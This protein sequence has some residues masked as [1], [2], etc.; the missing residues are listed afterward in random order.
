[1]GSGE[2]DR[3]KPIH[4]VTV[5]D[6]YIGRYSVTNEEYGR[7]IKATGYQEPLYWGDGNFN[8]PRQPVVSVRWYDAQAVARWA[9]LQF[10]SE[11]Q[12]E[13]ACRAAL[14]PRR[15]DSQPRVST[16]EPAGS[17]CTVLRSE[18]AAG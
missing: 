4:K 10:P 7:F 5:P 1:M 17:T 9:G 2:K 8:Q 16:C 14:P 3:E 13:Y 11:A 6:F 15:P 12:W 18:G